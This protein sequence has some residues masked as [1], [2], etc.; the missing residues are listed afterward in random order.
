MKE[1][2]DEA[3]GLE[4]SERVAK[5]R[6]RAVRER[7]CRASDYLHPKGFDLCRMV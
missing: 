4:V 7:R 5:A 1:R 2:E 3:G 6:E